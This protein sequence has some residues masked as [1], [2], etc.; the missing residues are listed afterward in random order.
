MTKH[1]TIRPHMTLRIGETERAAL[2]DVVQAISTPN[3]EP[4][5]VAEAMRVALLRGAEAITAGTRS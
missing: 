4:P 5:T 3:R 1:S 2:A